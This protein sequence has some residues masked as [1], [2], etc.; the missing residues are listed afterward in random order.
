MGTKKTTE[1]NLF[2]LYVHWPYCI[3][4]CPYCD[5]AS[6]VC[7]QPD[8][9]L[10]LKTY[11]RDMDF[12]PDKRPL[13]SLFFGGGTPSLMSLSFFEKLIQEIHKHYSFTPDIEI[14]LEANPDTINKAKLQG[15]RSLGINRLSIGIQALNDKDLKF[16]GRTHSAKRAVQC[17]HEAQ[18]LFQNINIDLIYARPQQSLK[19]WE[20]ELNQA[21][22]FDLPHY[23]LYQLTIE[24][25]TVFGKKNQQTA[26][27][28]QARRLYKL[29]DDIM[30]AAHKP[31]YEVSN[32]AQKGFEC[33]HNLTY[34]LGKDYI[35]IGPAAHG[36][37]GLKATSNAQTVSL[38]TRNMPRV[39]NLTQNERDLEKLLM[40][41]RLRQHSFATKKLDPIKI[42]KALQKGWITKTSTGIKPTLKGTLMLNS[43]VLLL[44]D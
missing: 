10:L 25:N 5:F 36:R 20:Q 43:L 7:K 39:E 1:T 21:L 24:E 32:Y 38:W 31:A 13:A 3:H 12:F 29:T 33:R 17:I 34:W 9:N 16:L 18:E 40:G 27:D 23:S 2:G 26:S 15:F 11:T 14:S 41:L 35:G 28:L 42:Q 44:A 19:A 8:E 30:N 6:T 4:K 37:L 22:K